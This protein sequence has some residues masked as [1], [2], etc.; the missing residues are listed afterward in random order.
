MKE[1]NIL[2]FL[3]L[4]YKKTKVDRKFQRRVVWKGRN[5]TSFL[6]SL[7]RKRA[8][9]SIKLVD[10]R[11]CLAACVRELENAETYSY[12]KEYK[13]QLKTS[14][15]YFKNLLAGGYFYLSLDG[16][17]R[18]E[19]ISELVSGSVNLQG[20][21]FKKG[22]SP[23]L[24]EFKKKKTYPELTGEI[25]NYMDV[26][27]CLRVTV[28][29]NIPTLEEIRETFISENDGMPLSDMEKT[30][31]IDSNVGAVIHLLSE[32]YVEL[33]QTLKKN[34]CDWS[35]KEDQ[36]WLTKIIKLVRFN[37]QQNTKVS[38][39]AEFW[40]NA[41]LLN[42]K[43][44][45]TIQN[46][47]EDLS[48]IVAD[49]NSLFGDKGTKWK[50]W[51]VL[52]SLFWFHHRAETE[53][54]TLYPNGL[55]MVDVSKFAEYVIDHVDILR[56]NSTK[57]YSEAVTDWHKNKKATAEPSKSSYFEH[58]QSNSDVKDSRTKWMDKAFDENFLKKLMSEETDGLVYESS[59]SAEE[60]AA[61][62]KRLQ[63]NCEEGEQQTE[64]A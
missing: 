58:W 1:C 60:C 8:Y 32:E 34:I 63:E 2:E 35:R 49:S 26:L 30:S 50:F 40:K 54:A 38:S 43:E 12:T 64:A 47:L 55:E 13:K 17:N 28:I 4:Y 36:D 19:T 10:I 18:A 9:S 15:A 27:Q 22:A 53:F 21:S 52:G 48:T 16:Q 39:H 33:F 42:K 51:A 24:V 20:V 11:S 6:T 37:G 5:K 31:A 25:K 3:T 14:K 7:F 62:L 29:D 61:F 44:F 46:I 23:V 57:E 45:E 56:A 59:H 41:K